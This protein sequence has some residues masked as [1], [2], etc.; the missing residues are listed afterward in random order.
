MMHN[1][2]V[3][4]SLSDSGEIIAQMVTDITLA[5]QIEG[6]KHQHIYSYSYGSKSHVSIARDTL[7]SARGKFY[8][9]HKCIHHAQSGT[10]N[11][12]MRPV[13][14]LKRQSYES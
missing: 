12:M 4:R 3:E 10:W 9:L 13:I 6:Q 14:G 8:H 2:F 11:S 5:Q 7:T 1:D